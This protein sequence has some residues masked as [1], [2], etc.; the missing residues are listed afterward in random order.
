VM[1]KTKVGLGVGR[2]KIVTVGVTIS[3]GGV[4]LQTLD[5]KMSKCTI[6]M[7]KWIKLHS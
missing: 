1:A 3:C 4:R 2:R 5:S 7:L 6:K